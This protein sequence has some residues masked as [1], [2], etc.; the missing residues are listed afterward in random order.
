MMR[1]A[2]DRSKGLAFVFGGELAWSLGGMI[3]RFIS[4]DD[5]WTVVFWRG[6]FA[7]AFLIVFMLAKNGWKSTLRSFQVMGLPGIAVACCF[8]FCSASFVI[9]LSNTTVANV[10]MLQSATPLIAALIGWAFFGEKAGL[11]TWFAIA[12]V[13]I[14]VFVMFSGGV[15]S[16]VSWLGDGLALAIAAVFAIA[17]VLTRRHANIAMMPATALGVLIGACIGASQAA[18]LAVSQQD[19]FSLFAFGAINLGLGLALFSMG[20]RLV[21]AIIVALMTVIEP[22]LGPVWVWL[23]HAEVPTTRALIG[24]T[25]ILGAL[26]FHV[27]LQGANAENSTEQAKSAAISS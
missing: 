23:V 1:M 17:I 15:N 18:S 11:A 27:L 3:S 25:F 5:A 7:A 26:L 24:G 12:A 20:A 16:E 13:A 21:P 2:S 14:G 10:L 4:I 19:M 6:V 22:V 9:A 8:A